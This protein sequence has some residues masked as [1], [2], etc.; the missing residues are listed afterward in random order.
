MTLDSA[1][2]LVQ[3][4]YETSPDIRVNVKVSHPRIDLENVPVTITGVYPHVFRITE[5]EKPSPKSYTVQYTDL[6][7]RQV[8]IIE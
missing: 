1:K 6:L 5:R 7:I 8:E 2:Q 3:R 4:L